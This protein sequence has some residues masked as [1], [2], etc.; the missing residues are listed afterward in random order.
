MDSVVILDAYLRETGV[1]PYSLLHFANPV[2][3]YV[4]CEI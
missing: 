4:C 2:Y 1:P 3:K